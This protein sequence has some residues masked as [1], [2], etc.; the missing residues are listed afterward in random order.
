MNSLIIPKY[1]SRQPGLHESKSAEIRENDLL[2]P[3]CRP[4]AEFAPSF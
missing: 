3:Q 4:S 1:V 2:T